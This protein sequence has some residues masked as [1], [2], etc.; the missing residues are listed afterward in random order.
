MDS[1][2]YRQLEDLGVANIAHVNGSFLEHLQGV[3]DLLKAW[4]NR[5]A[6]CHAGLFH[7]I[8]GS[9]G[10]QQSVVSPHDR[11][12]V[13]RIIGEEAERAVHMFCACDRKHFHTSLENEGHPEYRD[14]ITGEGRR[15]EPDEVRDFCE[16]FLADQLDIFVGRSHENTGDDDR[17]LQERL[18]RLQPFVSQG[19]Q[20]A[21]RKTFQDAAASIAASTEASNCAIVKGF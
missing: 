8:Y 14:R 13:A 4:G 18:G 1:S 10:F 11:E 3:H 6:L 7:S 17:R 2:V 12:R 21:F 20:E 16:I 9:A 5:E 19:A 15:L